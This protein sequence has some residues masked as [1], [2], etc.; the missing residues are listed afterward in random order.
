MTELAYQA[1]TPAAYVPTFTARVVAMPPG[2]IVLDRTFFY[3][4]GGGQPADRGRLIGPTGIAV[5][6]VD[7]ARSGGVVLHRL[8]RGGEGARA[9][10][11]G[12][13]VRGEIDWDRRFAHMRLHTGQHLASALLFARAGR[14]TDKAVLG[15]GQAIIDLEAPPPDGFDVAGWTREY[16]EA[17]ASDR[18][19]RV[20][21]L[22]HA[23]Y[24][25]AP[26]PRSGRIPLP[27]GIDRVR[28][29]EIEGYDAAPCGGT[30]LASTG[31]IAPVRVEGPTPATPRRFTF[32]L[33]TAA[34][35]PTPPG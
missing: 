33:G 32:T 10:H 23:E 13:E 14:R 16:E 9:F 2:A 7:V 28:L 31:P 15:K 17:I 34:A 22:T 30:H 4:V 21:H 8:R 24:E 25:A 20:R 29:I 26:A 18:P 27:A 3:A 1:D 6:V 19:V 11:V 12:D 35:P 5:E